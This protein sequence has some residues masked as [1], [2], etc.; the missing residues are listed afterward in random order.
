MVADGAL[1]AS[2][3][4]R[5]IQSHRQ[6]RN[7]SACCRC[8]SPHR[9]MRIW[10][11]VEPG[12]PCD[13]ISSMACRHFSV[14]ASSGKQAVL[15]LLAWLQ[16]QANVCSLGILT[17][18]S[19]FFTSWPGDVPSPPPTDPRGHEPSNPIRYRRIPIHG[20]EHENP[21]EASPNQPRPLDGSSWLC[22]GINQKAPSIATRSFALGTYF[23]MDPGLGALYAQRHVG[24][25]E[26][27]QRA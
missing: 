17:L 22:L 16:P 27:D 23:A 24:L 12:P 4:P 11:L 13:P 15:P 18:A 19:F 25:H 21:F 8:R 3:D 7:D 1:R 9:E 26:A 5:T 6:E 2:S 20:D 14:V 10:D